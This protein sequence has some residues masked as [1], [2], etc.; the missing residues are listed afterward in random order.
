MIVT[1]ASALIEL[2]AITM[3]SRACLLRGDLQGFIVKL[4]ELAAKS[5]ELRK[6]LHPDSTIEFALASDKEESK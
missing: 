4:T 6:E 2:E 1:I 3:L 5:E